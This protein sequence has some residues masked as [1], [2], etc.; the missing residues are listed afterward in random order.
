MSLNSSSCCLCQPRGSKSHGDSITIPAQP[1]CFPFERIFNF[2][3]IYSQPLRTLSLAQISRLWIMQRIEG[4]HIPRPGLCLV[5]R[6][7]KHTWQDRD[8]W[9]FFMPCGEVRKER[10]RLTQAWV[11]GQTLFKCCDPDKENVRWDNMK[12]LSMPN[13]QILGVRGLSRGCRKTQTEISSVNSVKY[14]S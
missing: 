8:P 10:E 9:T 4:T 2:S 7:T 6:V 1:D 3:L 5:L 12:V 14:N 11:S 13:L